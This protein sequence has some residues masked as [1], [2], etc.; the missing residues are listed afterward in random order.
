MAIGR[1]RSVSATQY[2]C[3][4]GIGGSPHLPAS[5]GMNPNASDATAPASANH[6]ITFAL[7]VGSMPLTIAI[8]EVAGELR[9]TGGHAEVHPLRP[10]N[11]LLRGERWMFGVVVAELRNSR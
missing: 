2:F 4:G 7:R 9:Y 1:Q 10:G 6:E 8:E 3:S 5:T 11:R